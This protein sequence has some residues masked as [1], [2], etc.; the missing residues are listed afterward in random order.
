[1]ISI[2]NTVFNLEKPVGIIYFDLAAPGQ[3]QCDK[4][5]TLY[6]CVPLSRLYYTETGEAV[7]YEPLKYTECTKQRVK[8]FSNLMA[9][10]GLK[11]VF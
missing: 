1:M 4:A 3:R 11:K 2:Y 5:Y 8:L 10:E 9:I 7:Y 6:T